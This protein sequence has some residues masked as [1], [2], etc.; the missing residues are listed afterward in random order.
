MAGRVSPTTVEHSAG[1]VVLRAIGGE[2][3]VLL[4]RDPYRKW[5]LPKGHLEAGEVH[6]DA[7]VREV[8]EE[9]GLRGLV[10]GPELGDIDWVFRA[11]PVRIHKHCRFFLMAS[12]QGDPAP[13]LSEGITEALWL[14]AEEAEA[15]VTYDNARE[16]IRK[17]LEHL[18]WE[19]L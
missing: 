9:T 11:G 15:T 8:E 16:M 4:I 14:P 18:P 2:A 1:G 7:A 17:A 5:G 13:Q 12:H 3:H 10:L 6:A 19:V